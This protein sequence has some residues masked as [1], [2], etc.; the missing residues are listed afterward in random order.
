MKRLK[1]ESIT[2]EKTLETLKE[3]KQWLQSE[4]KQARRDRA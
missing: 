1:H 4:M 2:P 3:D